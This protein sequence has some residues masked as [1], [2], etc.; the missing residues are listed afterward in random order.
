MLARLLGRL[1][2]LLVRGRWGE[3]VALERLARGT[4]RETLAIFAR[5]SWGEGGMNTAAAIHKDI[6]S[7]LAARPS[8]G[9][10]WQGGVC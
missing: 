7:L 4:R 8:D 6:P 5:G 1:E 2:P 3:F 10:E 9:R